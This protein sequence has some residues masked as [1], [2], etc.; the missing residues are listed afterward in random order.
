MRYLLLLLT[1]S[2]ALTAYDENQ[3]SSLYSGLD[4]NSITQ[5]IALYKLYPDQAI[6]KKALQ[7]A[8]LLLRKSQGEDDTLIHLPLIDQS[9]DGFVSF[10]LG[11]SIK[12]EFLDE[13]Y[14]GAIETLSANLGNRSLKG[15][16]AQTEAG[17]HHRL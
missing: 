3:L 17:F 10:M 15:Y 9:I 2:A 6:G 5:H 12:E 16:K 11:K 4:P 1:L 8:Q 14:L 7:H 13:K